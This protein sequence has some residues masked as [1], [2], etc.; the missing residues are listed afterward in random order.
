MKSAGELDVVPVGTAE[1]LYT[2]GRYLEATGG[3]WHLEDAP[4]KA[5][6]VRRMLARHGLH[7]RTVCEVGCGAGGVLAELAATLDA[8][9]R[10]DG[11]EI[12]PQAHALSLRFATD[13]LKF[14]LDD[15]FE[16]P[17]TYDLL[18]ALDVVEHVEDCYSFLRRARDKAEWKIYHFPLEITCLT[19][20][21]DY[22]GHSF[23][24][25]HLHFYSRSTALAALRHTG[26]EVIDA[27]F[28]PVG[29]ERGHRWRTRLANVPRRM[30][31]TPL[32]ARLLGGYSLL[33]LAR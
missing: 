23:A 18:L 25:G 33:V 29:L 16:L 5:K 2:D 24:A 12:S 10:F 11:F 14:R 27:D 3:R 32:A 6:Y 31:P 22:L 7:P 15:P 17:Q 13:R 19:A 8:D 28:T 4:F 20:V 26:H 21:R 1:A 9:T 30:L